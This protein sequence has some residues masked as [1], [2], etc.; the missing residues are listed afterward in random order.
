[1]PPAVL[2]RR[3]SRAGSQS[4]RRSVPPTRL[5]SRPWCSEAAVC[6]DPALAGREQA[7]SS[8][9]QRRP[10]SPPRSAARHPTTR[11]RDRG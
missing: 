11:Q 3:S 7:P 8:S 5:S 6:I 4:G 1:M 9:T 10:V 2:A